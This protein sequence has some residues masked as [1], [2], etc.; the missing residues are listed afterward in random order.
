MNFVVMTKKNLV[1][2]KTDAMFRAMNI[3]DEQD[4]HRFA[5][6][7]EEGFMTRCWERVGADRWLSHVPSKVKPFYTVDEIYGYKR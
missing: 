4:L 3:C 2:H 6:V 1:L 5:S 7:C